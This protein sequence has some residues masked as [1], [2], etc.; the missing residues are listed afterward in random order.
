MNILVRGCEGYNVYRLSEVVLSLLYLLLVGF[1]RHL[2]AD[3]VR[4]F[5]DLS[6]ALDID[7]RPVHFNLV[8]VKRSHSYRFA[9]YKISRIP[10]RGRDSDGRN[11][12]ILFA[13]GNVSIHI[14][15]PNFYLLG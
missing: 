9:H 12:I 10:A 14:I 4:E 11:L 8:K 13:Q 15:V 6:S 7:L 2:P 1:H 3:K 5:F